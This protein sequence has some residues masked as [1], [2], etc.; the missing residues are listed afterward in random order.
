[1]IRLDHKY[2]T[3]N[4]YVNAERSNRY[5]AA[6]IK[7]EEGYITKLL[8]RGVKPIKT[9]CGLRFHWH[10]THK[11]HDLDNIGFA[12]KFILDAMVDNKII[13]NDNLNHITR[14]EHVYIKDNKEFVEIEVI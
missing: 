5:K 7:R 2:T 9:P 10:R 11:R 14:I 3:L 6:K 12:S 13:P 4:E 8:L 1:M